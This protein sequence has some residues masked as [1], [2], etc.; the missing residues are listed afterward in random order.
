MRFSYLLWFSMSVAGPVSGL[1]DNRTLHDVIH[2][3]RRYVLFNSRRLS[4]ECLDIC[5]DE[6]EKSA[7]LVDAKTAPPTEPQ[8]PV[9]METQE[10]TDSPTGSPTVKITGSPTLSPSKNPTPSPTKN[11]TASPT[12]VPTAS[13]V[14]G[15][16][17]IENLGRGFSEATSIVEGKLAFDEECYPSITSVPDWKFDDSVGVFAGLN[18]QG[19]KGAG[20]E[21]KLVVLGNLK[22]SNKGPEN[23]VSVVE[24][25]H[26]VPHPNTDCII[27][28]GDLKADTK[29]DVYNQEDG[30]TCN[31]IYAGDAK[32]LSKWNNDKNF[33][34]HDENYNMDFYTQ[35][36]EVFKK[37]S[38]H[39]A[40]LGG[41]LGADSGTS[42]EVVGDE[43]DFVFKCTN[44]DEIQ[45]F[46]FVLK[47]DVKMLENED[48]KT[49][50]YS[51]E[52][53]DKTILI[54]VHK[55]GDVKVTPRE[56][57]HMNNYNSP[58]LTQRILWNFPKASKVKITNENSEENSE[59]YG[60]ILT[61]N[62]DGELVM[63]AR[64]HSGR[65]IVAGTIRHDD[66][67]S[68]FHSYPFKPPK[69][70]PD[71]PEICALKPTAGLD[72]GNPYY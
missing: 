18:Y 40:T 26:V 5:V 28:G 19:D 15:C 56:T 70:L 41:L 54:N 25:T 31:L 68:V 61:G 10:P 13:P 24:G 33:P 69:A 17:N 35:M 62:E 53:D 67:D 20:V 57:F 7:P 38:E 43:D 64:G 66:N 48:S 44:T 32:K 8:D 60:S 36:K 71:T 45:V 9:G 59:F 47:E 22:V 50:K 42:F 37:K 52:C 1:E 23:F 51:D 46:N 30:Q 4:G 14:V 12:S 16:T 49:F 34:Q 11:P 63:A 3:E 58:C 65:V 6:N 72:A 29:V 39:W 2:E 21:G 55:P 27:V